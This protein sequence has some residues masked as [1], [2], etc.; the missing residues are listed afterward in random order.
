VL[1]GTLLLRWRLMGNQ[2]DA[3]LN[4]DR[5]HATKVRPLAAS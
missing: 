1:A 2:L 5:E 4:V 3:V